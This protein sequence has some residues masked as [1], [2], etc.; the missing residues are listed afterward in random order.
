MAYRLVKKVKPKVSGGQEPDELPIVPLELNEVIRKYGEEIASREIDNLT[1]D[2]ILSYLLS[3]DALL[4][5][6]A[7]RSFSEFGSFSKE[8]HLLPRLLSILFF[9]LIDLIPEQKFPGYFETP[10]SIQPDQVPPNIA[11]LACN[12]LIKALQCLPYPT[13]W[14]WN[15]QLSKQRDKL[16]VEKFIMK[17]LSSKLAAEELKRVQWE[18]SD[19]V[20]VYSHPGCNELIAH[21]KIEDTNVSLTVT[22]PLNH[23]LGPISVKIS[24]KKLLGKITNL[25]NNR[26]N[27]LAAGLQLWKENLDAKYSGHEECAI[28]FFIIHGATKS[29]PKM[30]CKT[31]N[32]KFHSHCL[33]KWFTTSNKSECPLCRNLF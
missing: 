12:V 17:F 9:Q 6:H 25:L 18:E 23:P 24:D 14:W 1:D 20:T 22:L 29:L 26:S 11:H 28:C 16:M 5:M 33:Y 13:R 3:W 4:T 30:A 21:Y 15:S 19:N 32:H 8:P 10:P 27:S 2:Q 7:D 31:C